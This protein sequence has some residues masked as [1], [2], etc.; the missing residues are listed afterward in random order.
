MQGVGGVSKG[1]LALPSPTLFFGKAKKELVGCGKLVNSEIIF[2]IVLLYLFQY[3]AA[4]G[5]YY[6]FIK[7][8][9]HMGI[10][11]S[12]RL[13][14]S[15]DLRG[16]ALHDYAKR[17][18]YVDQSKVKDNVL[19]DLGNG[20]NVESLYE[21][22]QEQSEQLIKNY[23][24]KEGRGRKWRTDSK[25]HLMGLISFGGGFVLIQD[26]VDKNKL[27]ERAKEYVL[28]FCQKHNCKP[29][30]LMRH[31]DETTTHYHFKTTNVDEVTWKPLRLKIKDLKEE[32]TAISEVF[33]PMM[34]PNRQVF[35]RG[36]AKTDKLREAYKAVAKNEGE[37]LIDYRRR[38]YE[39]ANVNHRSVF[40]LH[41]DLPAEIA[42]IE[43][44]IKQLK[45][46]E[47]S[48]LEKLNT[49]EFQYS[50]LKKV[51]REEIANFDKAKA[52]TS[53]TEE[54]L[55]EL[56][57]SVD[58]FQ[59]QL[60]TLTKELENA[61]EEFEKHKTLKA[62]NLGAENDLISKKEALN[63]LEQSNKAL[64]HEVEN[65]NWQALQVPQPK[66]TT[67]LVRHE[68]KTIGKDT[69]ETEPLIF[70]T[71][72][73]AE[74][75]FNF[76]ENSKKLYQALMLKEKGLKEEIKKEELLIR[77]N[78]IS[79]QNYHL[80]PLFQELLASKGFVFI[81]IKRKDYYPNYAD[82]LVELR[83]NDGW[84]LMEK[85]V[86]MKREENFVFARNG[87][88]EDIAKVLYQEMIKDFQ[89]GVSEFEFE[90]DPEVFAELRNLDKKYTL[91]HISILAYQ[92]VREESERYDSAINQRDAQRRISK[93]HGSSMRY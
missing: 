4:I 45:A 1:G 49:L 71:K 50:A 82:Y 53:A 27:D 72:Q 12:V 22:A 21:F 24:S 13:Q 3:R 80:E 77:Q 59:G 92:D 35:K 57:A 38:V 26:E 66:K 42:A 17:P 16:Q 18:A 61:Q 20:V 36:V 19:I 75:F 64:I 84:V 52:D 40:Q 62:E 23:S 14:V 33:S 70:F 74:P 58:D 83:K 29:T 73:Q 47:E 69:L 68:A 63:K 56:K 8:G 51:V 46:G 90:G 41:R 93:Q 34:L 30:Y 44:T 67:R 10:T 39:K 76:A 55:A 32:Q 2:R 37:N 28:N 88:A 79:E 86:E 48:S 91:V 6:V 31:E 89:K 85:N 54:S 78:E 5:L 43:Q 65:V 11:V 15:K 9:F 60:L 81:L 25:T 7:G 87:S